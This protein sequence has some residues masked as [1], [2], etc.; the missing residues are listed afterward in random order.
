MYVTTVCQV[1]SGRLA[2]HIF[3]VISCCNVNCILHRTLYHHIAFRKATR[4]R[5]ECK[6]AASS[7]ATSIMNSSPGVDFHFRVTACRLSPRG[8]PE[9]RDQEARPLLDMVVRLI[10]HRIG[11]WA[12]ARGSFHGGGDDGTKCNKKTTFSKE[13]SHGI[14]HR[15][16]VAHKRGWHSRSRCTIFS[17]SAARGAARCLCGGELQ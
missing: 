9:A 7:V 4:Y 1:A 8:R 11:R 12:R 14:R 16:W 2:S 13:H 6:S 5:Q 3:R 15:R 17:A 10:E